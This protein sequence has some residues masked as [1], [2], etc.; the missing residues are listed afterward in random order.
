MCQHQ[1]NT[2]R[3]DNIKKYEC[4]EDYLTYVTSEG[5]LLNSGDITRI[6]A[7]LYRRILKRFGSWA[8]FME[9]FPNI[10]NDDAQDDA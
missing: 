4:V 1:Q 8:S 9:E 10:R 2:R 7:A 5:R 3:L 6:D